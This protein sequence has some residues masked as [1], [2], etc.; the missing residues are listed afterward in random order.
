MQGVALQRVEDAIVA[1]PPNTSWALEW[2]EVQCSAYPGPARR[3]YAQ[4][5]LSAPAA[6]LSVPVVRLLQSAPPTMSYNIRVKT[7]DVRW[8]GTEAGAD[9]FSPAQYFHFTCACVHSLIQRQTLQPSSH[10]CA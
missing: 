4:Q 2:L 3:F 8:A 5:P 10:H 9:L 7:A 6:G 1:I